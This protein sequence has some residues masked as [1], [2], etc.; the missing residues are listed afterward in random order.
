MITILFKAT[1][2]VR[3]LEFQKK[4]GLTA[5]KQNYA[6]TC[7]LDKNSLN[8]VKKGFKKYK[9]QI[10]FLTTFRQIR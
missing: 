1:E 7:I 6:Q 5:Q 3:F 8:G 10:H 4:I 9:V 2:L